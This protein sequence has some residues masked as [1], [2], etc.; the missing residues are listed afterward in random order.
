MTVAPSNMVHMYCIYF[1]AMQRKLFFNLRDFHIYHAC[2]W[3]KQFHIAVKQR[4]N[5]TS[6]GPP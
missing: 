6:G 4:Q 3:K 5:F 1:S 2:E